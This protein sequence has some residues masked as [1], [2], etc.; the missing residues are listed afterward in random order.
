MLRAGL[1]P[2]PRGRALHLAADGPARAAQGRARDPRGDE[3]RR[4]ARDR[5]AGRAAGRA[6]GGVRPLGPVRAGAAALQGPPRARHGAG[7][8]ARGGRDRPRAPRAQELPPAAGQLLPDPDQVPRRD[9][10]ALRRHARARV[11]HEGRLQ[12]PRRRGLA[13]RGLPEDVRRLQ[14]DL[15]APRPAL[16]RRARR[17]RRDRRQRLAGIPRARRLRR[18]RDRVLRRRRLR[19]EPRAGRGARRRATRAA[20]ARGACARSRRRARARSPTSRV[21]E[22]ARRRDCSRRWSSTAPTAAWSRCCCAATTS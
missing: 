14:R 18:G 19:R 22:A 6:L 4:R 8:D 21:P 3:P 11:R 15:H 20:A 1:D 5:D 13:R 2:A 10:A 17:H 9:P 16:P 12:L 7:P